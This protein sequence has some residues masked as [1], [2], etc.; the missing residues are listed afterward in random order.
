MGFINWLIPTGAA[1]AFAYFMVFLIN[2]LSLPPCIGIGVAECTTVD[3]S[4]LW[5]MTGLTGLI[6]VVG[7]LVCLRRIYSK[8]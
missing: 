5:L 3:R 1:I 8:D 6:L 4:A 7:A 2:Q